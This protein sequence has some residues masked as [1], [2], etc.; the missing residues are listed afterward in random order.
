VEQGARL[1]REFCLDVELQ[2][3]GIAECCERSGLGEGDGEGRCWREG[4]EMSPL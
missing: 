1:Q 2:A 3:E 4:S